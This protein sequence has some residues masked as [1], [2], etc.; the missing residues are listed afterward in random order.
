MHRQ[1]L[2]FLTKFLMMRHCSWL[3]TSAQ[4]A[5]FELSIKQKFSLAYSI[6][7]EIASS[8][9]I[10]ANTERRVIETVMRLLHAWYIGVI[11]TTELK[12]VRMRKE[13]YRD[14]HFKNLN[15]ST[16]KIES[17]EEI[18]S[19]SSLLVKISRSSHPLAFCK[20]AFQKISTNSQ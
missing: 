18:P 1:R 16:F 5:R 6:K 8:N 12:F 4:S 3:F 10:I 15:F 9:L 7:Y 17:V 2:I 13:L 20:N 11:Y 19:P 14:N